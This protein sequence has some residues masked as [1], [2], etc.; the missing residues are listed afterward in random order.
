MGPWPTLALEHER[1]ETEPSPWG[2]TQTPVAVVCVGEGVAVM[3][4]RRSFGYL[5]GIHYFT[6]SPYGLSEKVLSSLPY[7]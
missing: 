3:V 5:P 7:K 1:T 6:Q 4:A 2:D